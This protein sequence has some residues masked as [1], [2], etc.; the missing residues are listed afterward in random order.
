MRSI[1]GIDA[2][3]TSTQPSGVALIVDDASGWRLA[4]AASSYDR[5]LAH[6]STPPP[7]EG[8]PS[9]S[10][11]APGLLLV[12]AERMASWPV[13]LVAIDMPLSLDPVTSRRAA[14][15][16]VSVAYGARHCGTHSPSAVRPGRI[17]DD[18]QHEF[19][20]LG[21]PLATTRARSPCLMEVYPH[22]ALVELMSAP[23]RLPYKYSRAASY[24]PDETP[25]GR[26]RRIIEVWR[27]IVASLDTKIAGV[28]DQLVVPRPEAKGYELKAFEDMLDA[29]V[30]CWV[31]ACAMDGQ[32]LAFGN[33]LA[34]IWIPRPQSH[35]SGSD[36]RRQGN[37]VPHVS[38]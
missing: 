25:A 28:A 38:P 13:D 5:F 19:E 8:R 30:C 1:L 36:L 26:R 29:V 35:P 10:V 34:A 6:G 23:R 16:L 3:W 24:W 33:D 18:L 31:G 7:V 15:N 22:P 12:V 21:Y 14:D 4:A 20:A 2:A 17:S 27:G 37:V 9:G 32:A 11:P